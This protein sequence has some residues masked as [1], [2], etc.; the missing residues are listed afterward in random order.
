MSELLLETSG[1]SK[2]MC[3]EMKWLVLLEWVWSAVAD[4]S[5]DLVVLLL[6]VLFAEL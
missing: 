1:K 3:D 5:G 4:A 2:K 6:H